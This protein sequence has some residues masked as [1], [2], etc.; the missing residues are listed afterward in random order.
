[1]Q[2]Q[3]IESTQEQEENIWRLD[4]QFEPSQQPELAEILAD[5]NLQLSSNKFNRLIVEIRQDEH[6]TTQYVYRKYFIFSIPSP[7]LK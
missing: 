3:G 1:L 5:Y 6:L 7:I 2:A 4:I